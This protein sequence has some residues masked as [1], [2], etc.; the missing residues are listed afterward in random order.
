MLW[1]GEV[2]DTLGSVRAFG[3]SIGQFCQGFSG[4]DANRNGY[5]RPLLDRVTD[6]VP[7]GLQ[8]AISTTTEVYSDPHLQPDN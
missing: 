8:I 4:T 3:E 5:P 6:A 2:E 1:H 7:I